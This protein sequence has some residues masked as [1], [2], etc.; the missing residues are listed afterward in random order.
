MKN[1]NL[2]DNSNEDLINVSSPA[3]V[4]AWADKLDVTSSR[5]RAALNTV[6]NSAK[7]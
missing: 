4:K 7:K 1:E 3:L 5:L 6:G 2:A